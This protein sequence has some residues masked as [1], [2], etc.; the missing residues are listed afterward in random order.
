MV[1]FNIDGHAERERVGN[2][3]VVFTL[4]PSTERDW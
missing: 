4:P 1:K 3:N 2:T